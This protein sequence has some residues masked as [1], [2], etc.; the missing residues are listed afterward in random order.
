MTSHE[1]LKLTYTEEE[2]WRSHAYAKPHVEAGMRLHGGFDARGR[3]VP[4]RARVRGPAIQ[5]WTESLRSAPFSPS[6]SSPIRTV[7]RSSSASRPSATSRGAV[8]P[9]RS[10][11]RFRG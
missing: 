4:P 5:A 1:A 7:P 2:L 10:P 9:R 6:A 11:P 3:Y 8:V